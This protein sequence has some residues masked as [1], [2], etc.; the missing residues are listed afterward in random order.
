MQ[1][2]GS[3]FWKKR[4]YSICSMHR[5]YDKDC[6]MCNAGTWNNVWGLA[7][8]GKIY[9]INPV[10]WMWL[11]NDKKFKKGRWNEFKE[12]QKNLYN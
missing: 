3:L 10:L 4:W 7:I 5:E 9:D 6:N 11:V 1:D 8:M 12:T 2:K